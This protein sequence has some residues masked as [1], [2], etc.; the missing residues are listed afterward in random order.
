MILGEEERN[1]TTW[2]F[3]DLPESYL[4]DRGYTRHEHIDEFELI[5]M[6]GRVY[7]PFIARFL[8]PDNFVQEPGYSQNFNRYS[9]AYN[10]PLKFTDPDGEWIHLVIGA[11]IGGTI[12]W[13]T[14]GAEFSWDGAKYFG[15]GAA[16]GALGAGVGVGIQTACAGAS[17]WAG[18]VGS[19]QG[20]STILSCRLYK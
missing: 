19:S 7:D 9:Y 3:N 6:N 5:N 8:S 16:A 10:N 1:P 20:I 14:H 18:F 15:I 13:M 2:T 4:Y 12:N 17:F 11:V